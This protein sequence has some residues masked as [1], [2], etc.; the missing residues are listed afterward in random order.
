MC[1]E[2]K[3]RGMASRKTKR[4]GCESQKDENLGPAGDEACQQQPEHLTEEL[5][6]QPEP[7]TEEQRRLVR[8]NIGLVGVHLRR[9]LADL[10]VP[11]RDREGD[12]L[13]Q[14]GCLGLVQAARRFD[15]EGGIA[16]PA[17]ALPRIHKAVSK[18]LYRK[19]ATVRVPPKRRSK[20]CGETTRADKLDAE[21]AQADKLDAETAQADE[22]RAGKSKADKPPADD[23]EPSSRPLKR[24]DR[25][26]V[27]SL[28]DELSARLADRRHGGSVGPWSETIDDRLRLRYERAVSLAR[29][30]VSKGGSTRGDRD[31]LVRIP[32]AGGGV[33]SAIPADRPGDTV[34]VCPGRG[35]RP[36]DR[37]GHRPDP[38]SRSGVSR[39]SALGPNFATRRGHAH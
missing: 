21:T 19:F 23:C 9:H 18:A 8:E 4:H 12:D 37:P 39:T 24:P 5:R 26:V 30:T 33:A 14:E 7:L 17:Y 10:A 29:D 13:F 34:V 28:T 20:S 16:F 36:A 6:R 11:R 32:G 3:P 2:Q 25:P 27:S 15:P 38:A 22:S 31:A 1:G 35:V